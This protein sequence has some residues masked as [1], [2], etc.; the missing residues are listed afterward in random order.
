MP[1]KKNAKKEITGEKQLEDTREKS[2]QVKKAVVYLGPVITGVAIPGTVYRNGLTPQ[3]KKAVEE[4]PT[5]KRLLVEVSMAGRIQKELKDAQSAAAICYQK[6]LEY[7][8]KK[9]TKG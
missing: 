3:L 1:E 7:A 6:A 8:N 5:L 4:L 9:G 2:V